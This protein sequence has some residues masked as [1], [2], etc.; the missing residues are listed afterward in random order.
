M[1]EEIDDI[2]YSDNLFMRLLQC[3]FCRQ[4]NRFDYEGFSYKIL[5]TIEEGVYGRVYRCRHSATGDIVAIKH[6]EFGHEQIG[7]PSSVVREVSLLRALEH[8]NIIGLLKVL[9]KETYVNLVFEP[10][11]QDLGRYIRDNGGVQDPL[12]RKSFLWQI[13]SGVAYCHAHKV[14]HRDLKPKNLLF[15]ES[16][17]IIKIADFGLAREFGGDMPANRYYR[18]PELL[19]HS[20]HYSSEIDVWSVGCIFGEMVIGKPIFGEMGTCDEL[21]AIFRMLGTPSEETWPGITQYPLFGSYAIYNPM[22]LS[23]FFSALEPEGLQLLKM[24]LCLDPKR[25]ISAETALKHAYFKDQLT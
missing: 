6:I 14:L 16:R 7:V 10:L 13:L 20:D 15:D 19:L 5:Q 22:D 17:M 23:T 11:D 9:T 25:R 21:D 12:I 2:D 1:A 8:V 3:K 4:T 18:A 24:L